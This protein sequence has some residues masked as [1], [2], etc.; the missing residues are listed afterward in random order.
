MSDAAGHPLER[1]FAVGAPVAV[2]SNY[3]GGWAR[4]FRIAE[5]IEVDG[6]PSYRVRRY[7]D[8][9]LPALFPFQDVI[10]DRSAANPGDAIAG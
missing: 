6:V 4:G 3:D 1:L 2:R 5:V 9:V 8:V 10:P 7:D